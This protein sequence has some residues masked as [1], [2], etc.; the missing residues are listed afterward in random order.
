MNEY[1]FCMFFLKKT[2][3][4]NSLIYLLVIATVYETVTINDNSG[5][6]GKY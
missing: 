1:L 2:V 3:K 5:K 4:G 6:K